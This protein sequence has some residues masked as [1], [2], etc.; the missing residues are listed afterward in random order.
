MP[1]SSPESPKTPPSSPALA[2]RQELWLYVSVAIVAVE[3]LVT[4]VALCYGIITAPPQTGDGFHLAFPWLSWIAAMVIAPA[5]IIVA[6]HLAAGGLVGSGER[7]AEEDAAWQ[8]HLPERIQRLYRIMKGAPAI[9]LLLA[10]IL[11]GVTLATIDG[12]LKAL[13]QA[14]GALLPYLPYFIGG[15]VLLAGAVT[16]AMA[17]FRYKN[18]RLQAEYA[19]RREVFE[20]SGV[21]MVDTGSVALPPAGGGPLALEGGAASPQALPAGGATAGGD[22]GA[23]PSGGGAPG[24]AASQEDGGI[25]NATFVEIPDSGGDSGRTVEKP[26]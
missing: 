12:A 20:R 21:I 25:V 7:S 8:A 26:L 16:G 6:V 19:F 15:F 18:N 4:V 10:L 22:A 1:L 11:G 2:R 5:L 24:P 17:W 3:L 23:A 9:V 13:S 14:A